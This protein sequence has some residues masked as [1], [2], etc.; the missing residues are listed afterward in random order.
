MRSS[1]LLLIQVV[2]A[3]SALYT[4]V[5][6]IRVIAD[7]EHIKNFVQFIVMFFVPTDMQNKCAKCSV[8]TGN[9]KLDSIKI[10]RCYFSVVP[11]FFFFHY[12]F[13]SLHA[14]CWPTWKYSLM[15]CCFSTES[16]WYHSGLW[17]TV[18]ESE[19]RWMIVYSF[20][21]TYCLAYSLSNQT[22]IDTIWRYFLY[23]SNCGS[24]SHRNRTDFT[25][26]ENRTVALGIGFF[27]S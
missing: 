9:L 23:R 16:S 27:K 4:Q 19:W 1:T 13:L 6:S 12:T 25:V 26:R 24:S 22:V 11:V 8:L 2:H 10:K 18:C 21:R 3:I 14:W 15:A 20:E 5:L 7:D 17:L